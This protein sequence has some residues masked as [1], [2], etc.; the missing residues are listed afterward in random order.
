MNVLVLGG[1]G[2]VGSCVAANLAERGAQVRVMT[3]NTNAANRL[4]R[5]VSLCPGDLESPDTL[6]AAFD[7]ADAVFLLNALSHTE[8]E[9]GV[10]AVEAAKKAGVKKIVYLSVPLMEDNKHIP[11][12]KSKIPIEEAIRQSGM[13]YTLLRPNNFYQNDYW[14]REAILGYRIY[15]QPIGSIGLNRVD[16]RDIAEAAVNAL[17]LD[18]Y[19]GKEYP[20]VGPEPLTGESTANIYSRILGEE[21]RYGGDDLDAWFEQARTVMPEWMAEDLKIMYQ[22]FQDK[23]LVASERDF[24]LQ[25]EILKREP[26]SFEAFVAETAAIWKNGR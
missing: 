14:Y 9:Q 15:P 2:T 19:E 3:R 17:L 10:A 22:Y 25:R 16:A 13:A 1:T 24:E 21:I 12:F 6:A 11:H 26:L 23:G 20:V 18:G 7:R 5:S 8:T 4:P